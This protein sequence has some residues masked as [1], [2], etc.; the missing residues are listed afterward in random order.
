MPKRNEKAMQSLYRCF[1][2]PFEV[3]NICQSCEFVPVSFH[4]D[5]TKHVKKIGQVGIVDERSIRL[6]RLDSDGRESEQPFQFSPDTEARYPDKHLGADTH[7]N[8]SWIAEWNSN[9]NLIQ[10]SVKG[11]FTF[12][13]QGN[14]SGVSK[15]KLIFGIPNNT[16]AVQVPFLPNNLRHF[17]RHYRPLPL[18][19]FPIMQIRPQWPHNGIVNILNNNSLITSYNMGL[20]VDDVNK[21]SV[22]RRPFFYPVNSPDG[23]SVTELGKPHDPTGSHSHHYSLWIAHANVSGIDFWSDKGGMICHEQFEL[24]EDGAI[25]S[26]LIQRTKWLKDN[27][28]FI[29]ERRIVTVYATPEDFRLIDIEIELNSATSKPVE[30]GK[31]PF[32]LLSARVAQSMTVFDGGGEI[33]NS[34]GQSNEQSAFWQN[35]EWIDQSGPIAPDKWA[36]IAIFDHPKNPRYP[37]AW[38]CRNDGWAGTSF[39]LKDPYLIEPE[40]PLKLKYR[41]HIHRHNSDLGKVALRYKE[42]ICDPVVILGE[43]S[44]LL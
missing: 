20:A 23:I 27:E 1:S 30:L 21:K 5:L 6:F 35:A 26:R 25:F 28:A 43:V 32:G 41:V 37:V 10:P 9:E 33:I 17:D 11:M 4:I 3:R 31:T 13:A 22:P 8:V 34:N 7:E 18:R 42:F 36:G 19:W 38:H 16:I 29:S 15:Y 12:V 40:N 2:L 14:S 44:Q 24:M 39:N